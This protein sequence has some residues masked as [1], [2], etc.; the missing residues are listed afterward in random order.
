MPLRKQPPATSPKRWAKNG[1]NARG[2]VSV[3]AHIELCT[4]TSFRAVIIRSSYIASWLLHVSASDLRQKPPIYIVRIGSSP[5]HALLIDWHPL[6][7]AVK[8]IL[9]RRRFN[10][11]CCLAAAH[12]S[13][14]NPYFNRPASLLHISPALD[15][16]ALLEPAGEDAIPRSSC[17]RYYGLCMLALRYC[18]H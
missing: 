2:P 8:L 3:R 7:K 15:T 6:V 9:L 11:R 13:C 17:S 10:L 1:I 5:G 16:V 4:V 18:Y 12:G 14:L